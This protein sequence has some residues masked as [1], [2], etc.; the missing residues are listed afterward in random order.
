MKTLEKNIK[1]SIREI[2]GCV[3]DKEYVS[4]NQFYGIEKK[5]IAADMTKI[6][7][8]FTYC[9]YGDGKLIN[10][11]CDNIVNAFPLDVNWDEVCPKDGS[12]VY[13][14]GNPTYLGARPLRQEKEL[15]AS[16]NRVFANESEIRL[17]DLDLATAWMYLA[18]V[19]IA[20][21]DGGFAFVTTNSLTQG[22]H[23]PDLWPTLFRKGICISFAYT[24]FKWKNEGRNNIAVTVVVL[25]CRDKRNT[26]RK[27]IY[28][29]D[30][31]YDA[32]NISPYLHKG[33]TIVQEERTPICA[34]MPKM[35]KG[36][37]AAECCPNGEHT[38]FLDAAEK[39]EILSLHPEAI[40]ILRRAVGSDEFVKRKE[41]W[42][43]WVDD[44]DLQF[45]LEIP[46]IEERIEL[47][48]Q[49]RLD[50]P[51]S[52]RLADRPHQF[53]ERYMPQ[54]YTLVV[55]AVTGENRGYFQIGYV[56]KNVVVTNL[57][58]AIYDAEPWV[59]GLLS[60]KMHHIWACTVCGGLETRPR[61]SNVL[62]Y[63]TF[64]VPAL[65]EDQKKCISEA[66]MGVIMERENYSEMTLAEMYNYDTMPESLK[67][68]HMIL[69]EDVEQCYGKFYS[70]QARL[71]TLFQLYEEIKGSH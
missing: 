43:L 49:Y 30:K 69:D 34:W 65:S 1:N 35:R 51:S 53:R 67:A 7:M 48:R 17:G 63:N 31:V 27:T 55:P 38:L 20:G 42:C 60:S 13:I 57:A 52:R 11:Y 19:Y 40:R 66:A 45:A 22:K 33:S 6:G 29:A 4:L 3:E 46:F 68:A 10:K 26:H 36:N 15:L 21:T 41:R 50:S 28:D 39:D 8:A 64:P 23:V 25:G 56:G 47:T 37:M 70:D 32:D 62:G 5:R 58:F 9:K 16:F 61:Y 54:K 14:I 2:G 59:F 18:S 44:E 24:R 71:D 12:T